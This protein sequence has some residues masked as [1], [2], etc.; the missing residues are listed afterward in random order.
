MSAVTKIAWCDST[1][2]PWIGCTRIGLGCDNC[3]AEQQDSR[4]RWGGTTHW[5]T[6][7]ARMRTSLANWG[8]PLLWQ[9]HAEH[10]LLPDGETP[11][12][13]R[14]PRVFCS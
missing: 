9:R 12:D 10:G 13:G 1:F 3:Y 2:N 4:K 14:A 8:K 7:K 11:S 6:G 5:G